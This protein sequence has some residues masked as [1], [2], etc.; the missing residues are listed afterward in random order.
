MA[1][2]LENS[3]FFKNKSRGISVNLVLYVLTKF[4]HNEDKNKMALDSLLNENLTTYQILRRIKGE[5]IDFIQE[6][7]NNKKMK[8]QLSSYKEIIKFINNS[9]NLNKKTS[10]SFQ[11][12]V[13]QIAYG[14]EL[15]L[16]EIDDSSD[17]SYVS[18]FLDEDA[19][20]VGYVDINANNIH[21]NCRSQEFQ[22]IR[23]AD[24]LASLF[25]KLLSSFEKNSE[26]DKGEPQK[27]KKLPKNF[28]K[29]LSVEQEKL[30]ANLNR[31]LIET[32]YN[33][34]IVHSEYA[35]YLFTMLS[36]FELSTE[37]DHF[38][39]ENHLYLTL[40]KMDQYF[41]Q[42]GTQGNLVRAAG[43]SNTKE[44]IESKLL[45]PF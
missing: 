24:L 5:M 15:W 32:P 35:D 28:F 13:N 38:D 37:S 17:F 26:Y 22:G 11:F 29:K 6:N 44:A 45:K 12:P 41:I 1:F 16:S 7:K 43:F 40:S 33:F 42:M 10:C 2:L 18:L 19:P 34:S 31:L 14:L 21:E 39:S 30:V 25:G 3:N 27:I 36:W 23:A 8:R 4:I 20:K 9:G